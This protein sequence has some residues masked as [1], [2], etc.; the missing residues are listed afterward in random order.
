MRDG[1]TDRQTPTVFTECRLW[2]KCYSYILDNISTLFLLLEETQPLLLGAG[3]CGTALVSL[4]SLGSGPRLWTGARHLGA[5]SGRVVWKQNKSEW[6]WGPLLKGR[7]DLGGS[8]VPKW[9]VSHLCPSA[10]ESNAS[11]LQ[12]QRDLNMCVSLSS[13]AFS[14]TSLSMQKTAAVTRGRP[15]RNTSC[16]L[17]SETLAGR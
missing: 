2:R 10:P 11:P 7:G 16:M 6:D 9:L 15:A 1:R 13:W 17:A 4:P 3:G 12:N 5:P 14:S 8:R